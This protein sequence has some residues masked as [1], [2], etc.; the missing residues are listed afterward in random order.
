MSDYREVH[1]QAREH[2]L[3]ARHETR[4]ERAIRRQVAEEIAEALEGL[5]G[6][7]SPLACASV[8]RMIG[9]LDAGDYDRGV[10]EIRQKETP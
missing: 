2:G 10:R 8:A 4:V 9:S 7:A 3:K 1:E 5:A 6:L